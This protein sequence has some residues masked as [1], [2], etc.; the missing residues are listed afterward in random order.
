[1]TAS[2]GSSLRSAARRS[3]SPERCSRRCFIAPRK[4]S[5]ISSPRSMARL[6]RGRIGSPLW[7]LGSR[8]MSMS[9]TRPESRR[10]S[11][12]RAPK[13]MAFIEPTVR[14][15][16]DNSEGFRA[17]AD[18]VRRELLVSEL[19]R[20]WQV[21]RAGSPEAP[22]GSCRSAR[23]APIDRPCTTDGQL[24]PG[25]DPPARF[26][27][28]AGIGRRCGRRSARLRSRDV[29]CDRELHV[30]FDARFSIRA[31]CGHRTTRRSGRVYFDHRVGRHPLDMQGWPC[32]APPALRSRCSRRPG[33]TPGPP[34]SRV[35]PEPGGGNE[36]DAA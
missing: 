9:L 29:R 33:R 15:Y 21:G 26:P 27:S 10:S 11:L 6:C 35:E 25:A 8:R 28:H 20:Y 1:M 24:Y 19:R 30:P 7:T 14:F 16:G 32:A 17:L 18:A 34:L 5:S 36:S 23:L 13:G 12:A 2:C 3:A 31:A 4:P 22:T